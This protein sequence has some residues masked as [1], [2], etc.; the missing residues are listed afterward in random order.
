VFFEESMELSRRFRA[1]KV[2]P[3][4][5]YHGLGAYRASIREDL[6]LAQSLARRIED[7]DQLELVAPVELSAVCFR[8]CGVASADL[9]ELNRWVLTAV[10]ERGRVYI[11]QRDCQRQVRAARASRITERPQ[12]I[13]MC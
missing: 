2:W 8:A 12:R 7:S 13:S 5:R 4:L 3:S 10:N 1:L 11:L 9:D 6:D